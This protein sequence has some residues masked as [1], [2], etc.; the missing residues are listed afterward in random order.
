MGTNS[1][2]LQYSGSKV[3]SSKYECI[4]FESAANISFYTH[5]S[6]VVPLQAEPL[7]T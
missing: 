6:G 2:L 4:V 5:A 1:C 7:L 3:D